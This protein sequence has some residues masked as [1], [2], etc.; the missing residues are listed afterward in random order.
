MQELHFH[1]F[2]R[3][4]VRNKH[5]LRWALAKVAAEVALI[6]AIV[7]LSVRIK[8]EASPD[9][10]FSSGEASFFDKTA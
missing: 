1:Y 7:I 8:K 10:L 5:S 9:V 6:Q 4:T 3:K 2:P